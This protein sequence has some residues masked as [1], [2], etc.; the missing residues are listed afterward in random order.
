MKSPVSI[1]VIPLPFIPF[2]HL[3]LNQ[4]GHFN[5]ENVTKLTKTKPTNPP[6]EETEVRSKMEVDEDGEIND[7]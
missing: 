6:V 7:L 4:A 2:S 3:G 5:T 1:C